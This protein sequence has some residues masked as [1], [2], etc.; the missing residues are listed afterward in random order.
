MK[1]LRSDG[2]QE[3]LSIIQCGKCCPVCYQKMYVKAQIYRTIILLLVCET[4]SLTLREEHTSRLRVV[5]NAVLRKLFGPKRNEVTGGFI[6][7]I[8]YTILFGNQ[9][10]LDGRSMWRI[11]DT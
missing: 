1:K 8:P 2:S 6:I 9:E 11:W 4:R 7:F 5:E 10:E 3:I